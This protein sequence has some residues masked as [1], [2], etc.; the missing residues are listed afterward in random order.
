MARIKKELIYNI[1]P[2]KQ[3]DIEMK[4]SKKII[5]RE[6]QKLGVDIKIIRLFLKGGKKH[7]HS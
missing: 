3:F 7:E 1:L 6:M 2:K 5:E 4:K